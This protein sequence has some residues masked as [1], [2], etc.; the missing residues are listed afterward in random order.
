MATVRIQVRRG[1]AAQWTSTNPILAAGEMGVET[2]SNLFK[3][4]NGTSTWTALSYANNSDV[5]I[6]E[7]SQDAINNAL[8]L[9]AGLT[10]TYN[11][12]SNT[13]EITVDSNVIALKSYVDTAVSGLANTA[14]STYIP[15]DDRGAV[16]GVASLNAQ[17][18]VPTSEI[19]LTVMATREYADYLQTQDLAALAIHRDKTLD[20]HGIPDTSLLATDGDVT[21]ALNSANNYTD[22][23]HGEAQNL[24]TSL[25]TSAQTYADTKKAEA[26]TAAEAYAD[27]VGT[28]A[29][30]FATGEVSAHNSD[31]SN[32]HG[33]ADTLAL[34]T[35]TYADN[36]ADAAEAAAEVTANT[37]VSDHNADTTDVHGIADTANLATKSYADAA[38]ADAITAA[39]SAADSKVAAAV[40]ALTKSSVGL[41][42]VDNTSDANK[43]VSTATQT[44]LNLKANLAGPTFTGTVVLPSTTSIGNVSA[45][46][47][48]Y[49]DGVT[50]AIQTQID[51][52]LSK[53]GGT[54]TGDLTLAGAPTSDLHAVTKAYVDNVSSGLNFHKPVRVATTANITLSGT[55]TIDGVALSVGDRVL[56]KDQSN[57]KNNGIY[58]VKSAAWDRA[59]DADNN[60][61]GE[62]AGGDFTL[63]LEGTVNSGYGYVCS[64][65]SAI[66]V[67]TTDVTYTPFN[68]AKTIT[69][70]S[71]LT[72]STP[73][74]IDIATGGVTSAMIADG[75][76][77]DGDIN[78]SAAIA[79]SKISGLT[80]ALAAKAPLANPTFTGTVTVGS[81]GV[82]F[83][84]GTQTK[85]GVPSRTSIVQKTASYTLSDLT[86]RDSL[87]EVAS[88]SATTITI[89]AD[90]AVNYPVGT[91][92]DILQTS[93]GQVTIAGAGGVTINATPGLKL[94]TQWSSA[95]LLKRAAN[96]WIV[97]GDLTA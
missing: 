88:G 34:A 51:S 23:K 81:A 56:V 55:Q 62:I 74:T 36:A 44:A 76:I 9:G 37:K 31:T 28:T 27:T 49:V 2:D 75:T 12:G 82:A 72:E 60:P 40:A 53:A 58:E 50:S 11:D 20:V 64:N 14:D 69:A 79:Q 86:E 90:S 30:S 41:A 10:K 92:I 89:P 71:G 42:N 15:Q 80:A 6:G 43:P 47:L 29:A 19:D 85:E 13:I 48:E 32:V 97:M 7:I 21:N 33:I 95:S 26:I 87:I 96:T 3:F 73:G 70:G 45:T 78:A 8:S 18:K 39:G 66:T 35:K 67:G 57:Q 16:N 46:E 17:G 25:G 38:E 68:A 83:T 22:T 59:A 65:T 5:S 91:S 54:M 24:I 61:S 4:G 52:K 84:D 93:T 94:R 63:V 77:V 1:T